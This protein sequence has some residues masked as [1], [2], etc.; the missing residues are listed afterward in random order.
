MSIYRGYRYQE[1]G[2]LVVAKDG[3]PLS[4]K[5]SQKL[6]NHSPD[7]FQWGYGGSGPAQL[8][9]A[10]L[11][12]VTGDDELSVRLHQSFKRE[13]VAGW[14]EKWEISTE[15]IRGWIERSKGL[16]PAL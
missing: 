1:V 6:F 13:F 3:Q 9:L 11:L 14:K 2:S 12:D 4:P 15:E 8:S 5:P 16:C 7:G 10:L